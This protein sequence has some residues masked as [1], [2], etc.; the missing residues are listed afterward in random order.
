MHIS[1]LTDGKGM[2]QR[3]TLTSK[4][5]S[6]YFLRHILMY[7]GCQFLFHHKS[8]FIFIESVFGGSVSSQGVEALTLMTRGEKINV[9]RNGCP[10]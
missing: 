10:K 4:K 2:R 8:S 5:Y 3:D 6:G 9:W 1:C 7:F